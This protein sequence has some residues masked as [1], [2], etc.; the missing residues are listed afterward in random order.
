[1]L[2]HICN[3]TNPMCVLCTITGPSDALLHILLRGALQG[4]VLQLNNSADTQLSYK[5][6]LNGDMLNAVCVRLTQQASQ[7]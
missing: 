1:M 5:A 2:C 4:G 6:A 7:L 3:S